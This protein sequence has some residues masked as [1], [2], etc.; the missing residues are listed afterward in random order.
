MLALIFV[1]ILKNDLITSNGKIPMPVWSGF[2]ILNFWIPCFFFRGWQCSTEFVT[3]H[4]LWKF[5][6]L[7]PKT[8]VVSDISSNDTLELVLILPWTAM[9]DLGERTAGGFLVALEDIQSKVENYPFL[10]KYS[11]E[12]S[13]INTK[14]TESY[15]L[16]SQV[17]RKFSTYRSVLIGISCRSMCIH[18]AQLAGS[19][20]LPFISFGCMQKSL[21]N[22]FKFPMFFRT[23]SQID[24][25]M[26]NIFY[27]ILVTF[28]WYQVVFV[29]FQDNQIDLSLKFLKDELMSRSTADQNFVILT[30]S[31]KRKEVNLMKLIDDSYSECDITF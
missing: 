12:W 16:V 20:N 7:V 4:L 14:C 1:I 28:H 26:V 19:F 10:Q 21:S 18:L 6:I 5:A 3:F 22:R 29:Q 13:F 15:D 25:W 8:V 24:T 30:E 17:I 2:G 11:L 31:V 27:D 23:T 9:D